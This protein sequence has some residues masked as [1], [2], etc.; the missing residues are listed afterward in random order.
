MA[1]ECRSGELRGHYGDESRG[2]SGLAWIDSDKW[3]LDVAIMAYAVLIASFDMSIKESLIVP[4]SRD[5]LEK[6]RYGMQQIIEQWEKQRCLMDEMLTRKF[7]LMIFW[8]ETEQGLD[9]LRYLISGGDG[10]ATG[11]VRSVR[12]GSTT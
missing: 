7:I 1:K 11:S 12:D 2:G 5:P 3:A 10:D 4:R 6:L 8:L 9:A